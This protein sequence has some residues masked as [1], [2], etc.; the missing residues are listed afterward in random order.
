MF[1]QTQQ[2]IPLTWDIFTAVSSVC[3]VGRGKHLCYNVCGRYHK[4]YYLVVCST[5]KTV[6]TLCTCYCA[7]N[8]P[9][10]CTCTFCIVMSSVGPLLG[11]IANVSHSNCLVISG[12]VHITFISMSFFGIIIVC[13]YTDTHVLMS[14]QWSMIIFTYT[15]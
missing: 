2:R 11:Y 1:C 9:I 8:M 12:V 15:T 6:Y 5:C 13:T 3:S 14:G 4:I 7:Y 10:C